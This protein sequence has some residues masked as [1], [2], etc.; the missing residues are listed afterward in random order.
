MIIPFLTISL[1]ISCSDV[2][3][4]EVHEDG[5][6]VAQYS[7]QKKTEIRHGPYQKFANGQLAEEGVYQDGQLHGERILY[8]ANGNAELIENYEMD[9]FKGLYQAFYESGAL[10]IEGMYSSGAMN[11]I[12]KRYYEPGQ[13]MEEVAFEN[14]EENGPFIEYYENGKLKAEGQYR[15]GDNEHGLLKL[16]DENGVLVKTMDCLNGI[17]HTKW[18]LENADADDEI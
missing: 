2:R 3:Q 13:L 10:H 12:W 17:C 1:L 7:V 9:E 6:L 16:Y 14:N 4:M 11:G 18:T 8:Y 5:E 15:N